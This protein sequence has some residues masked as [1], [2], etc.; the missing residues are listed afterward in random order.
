M[1]SGQPNTYTVVYGSTTMRA[2]A[3][4]EPYQHFSVLPLLLKSN[5][6]VMHPVYLI[7]PIITA[8][9]ITNPSRS[10][11]R[12]ATIAFMQMHLPVLRI[13][14][15]RQVLRYYSTWRAELLR[16]VSNDD[17][18]QTTHMG[19]LMQPFFSKTT[20][21]SHP[22]MRT[23]LANFVSLSVIAEH[24]RAILATEAMTIHGFTT[25]VR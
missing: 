7:K 22:H 15:Q 2:T 17:T 19:E 1:Q 13:L 10:Y 9:T 16:H 14:Q 18:V 23:Q 21:R 3:C 12:V 11:A 24:D 5:I 25:H 20:A 6:R 8:T 4:D